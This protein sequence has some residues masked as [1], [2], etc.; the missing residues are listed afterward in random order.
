M[1]LIFIARNKYNIAL[2]HLC[3]HCVCKYDE[4]SWMFH[5]KRGNQYS[6]LGISYYSY[7]PMLLFARLPVFS[8][9]C[10][11]AL[12]L[13]SMAGNIYM[14]SSVRLIKINVF[15]NYRRVL[16]SQALGRSSF[17]SHF[18]TKGHFQPSAFLC[19]QASLQ[20]A[21]RDYMHYQGS[22]N[23]LETDWLSQKSI[24]N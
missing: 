10:S 1:N 19:S 5:K 8:R 20:H 16:R 14:M 24:E 17:C 7:H 13:D 22:L 12:T 15:C 3:Y 18:E 9:H 23:R 11:N 4:M 2:L 21:L 6:T